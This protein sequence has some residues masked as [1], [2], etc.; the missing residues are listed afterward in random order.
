MFQE[1]STKKAFPKVAIFGGP[2]A[3]KT[4][5]ALSAGTADKPVAVID[6]EGGTDMM[7]AGYIGAGGNRY[8]PNM[9][10]LHAQDPSKLIQALDYLEKNA[11]QFSALVIDSATV[12]WQMAQDS[13][14][15]ADTGRIKLNEWNAVKLPINR[16]YH[17]IM[18]LPLATI[19]SCRLKEL[20]EKD[21]NEMKLVGY[22]PDFEKGASYVFDL[23]LQ[24]WGPQHDF[25]VS[26][27]KTRL[28]ELPHN[29]R[30]NSP[31][32]AA[33]MGPISHRFDPTIANGSADYDPEAEG[34]RLYGKNGVPIPSKDEIMAKIADAKALP[35]LQ[36]IVKKYNKIAKG[37]GWKQELD[38]AYKA[39][40]DQLTN[41]PPVPACAPSQESA[42]GAGAADDSPQDAAPAQGGEEVA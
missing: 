22:A 23:V 3:G 28:E 34:K 17:R 36:N 42:S 7:A 10:V 13:F 24:F 9:R 8:R 12:I 19:F 15:Q 33:V 21:G 27:Y 39:K 1:P 40:A 31:D 30:L 29:T 26:V 14:M 32:W 25:A 18:R 11:D 35:H 5:F 6:T 38:D 37:D 4:A 41:T 2:G 20:F 16:A